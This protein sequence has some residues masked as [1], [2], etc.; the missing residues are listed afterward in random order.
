MIS[1]G[2]WKEMCCWQFEIANGT[3][4]FCCCYL[5]HFHW[6]L[7]PVLGKKY[8]KEKECSA[9]TPFFVYNFW[10]WWT[11]KINIWSLIHESVACLFIRVT[12]Q[13]KWGSF[14]YLSQNV[15]FLQ[16]HKEFC[17]LHPKTFP[18]IWWNPK[19]FQWWTSR[20]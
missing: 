12:W 4:N 16:S 20:K 15:K 18:Q 8:Q 19:P 6:L 10:I 11:M 13:R 5:C 2:C 14:K 9:R 3:Y 17:N 7:L 1:D